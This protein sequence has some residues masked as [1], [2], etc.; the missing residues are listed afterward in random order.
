VN[1]AFHIMSV[2]RLW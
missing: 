1:K 2:H